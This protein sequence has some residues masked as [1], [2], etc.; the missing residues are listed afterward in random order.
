[1]VSFTPRLLYP[2]EKST[3]YPLDRRLGGS[4]SRPEH[5]GEEKN[6]LPLLGLEP[7]IMQPI[8]QHYVVMGKICLKSIA[9]YTVNLIIKQILNS[10][11]FRFQCEP[12]I[13]F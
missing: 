1:V 8:A 5:G 11:S 13:L 9:I 3:W 12:H 6:S 4:Q 7:P 2:Q 10:F